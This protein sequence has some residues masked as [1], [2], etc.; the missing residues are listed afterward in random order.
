L[1]L[2]NGPLTQ[3]S[4]VKGKVAA[5]PM[6]HSCTCWANLAST[7]VRLIRKGNLMEI[8][9]AP[10]STGSSTPA[11]A[12]GL[13][14]LGTALQIVSGP[15]AQLFPALTDF[16]QVTVGRTSSTKIVSVVNVGDQTLAISGISV[17]GSNSED[18]GQS[19]TCGALA[20]NVNCSV[21]ILFLPSQAVI[22]HALLRVNTN[23][24][25]SQEATLFGTGVA[26]K[27]AVTLSPGNVDF[28]LLAQG[29]MASRIIQI[30]NSGT[31]VLHISSVALSG[32]NLADF[33]QTNTCLSVAIAVQANCTIT[34]NFAPQTQGQR[35]TSLVITDDGAG[36]PHSVALSGSGAAPFQLSP[37][38]STS[39]TVSA[40]QTG[41]TALYAL[42]AMPGRV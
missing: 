9:G 40:G 29:T 15:A 20:R 28:D 42:L 32:S 16:G 36:S 26:T 27:A 11:G 6:G 8:S 7:S 14:I 17:G 33:S 13:A 18:F 31:S 12:Q 5:D 24:P 2:L 10:F 4:F 34:A 41:Q 1:T 3:F 23:A 35:T 22:E 21:S 30:T 19:N 39:S 25:G 38:G 37:S